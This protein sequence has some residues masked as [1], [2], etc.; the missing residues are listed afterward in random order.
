MPTI[1]NKI[2]L[3]MYPTTGGIFM[4]LATYPPIKAATMSRIISLINEPCIFSS[5]Y[6]RLISSSLRRAESS[7]LRGAS[8]VT[9]FSVVGLMNEIFSA[10]RKWR[11]RYFLSWL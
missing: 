7:R 10:C 11:A 3:T 4:V 5:I 6:Y 8:Y 2:P 1:P 9:F